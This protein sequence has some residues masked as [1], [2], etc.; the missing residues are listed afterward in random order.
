[1]FSRPGKKLALLILSTFLATFIMGWGTA[2]ASEN[3]VTDLPAIAISAGVETEALVVDFPDA[4]LAFAVRAALGLA[5]GS[6]ITDADLASLTRLTAEGANIQDLSGLEY[7]V[8]LNYLSLADN[9][10]SDL[11]SLANL[12]SLR[13]MS[14]EN[15]QISDLTPL[16]NLT[17]MQ[18]LNLSYNQ[19]T[20][21]SSLANL[22][23]LYELTLEGNQI[24]D[25]SVL[26][27]KKVLWVLELG[28][29]DISDISPLSGA[30][31]LRSVNIMNNNVSDISS[32]EN[33][34]YLEAVYAWNNQVSDITPLAGLA[35]LGSIGMANNQV[36]D[37]LAL[38]GLIKLTYLNLDNNMDSEGNQITDI[39]SLANLPWLSTLSLSYNKITDISPLADLTNLT[40]V[41]V[42]YNFIDVSPG[43]DALAVIESL[44]AGGA[45]VVYSPQRNDTNR[46]SVTYEA[47]G[48]TVGT[49]PLDSNNYSSG[50]TVT[51]K[52]N[53]GGLE[54]T[55]YIFGGWN[56]QSNGSG[57]NYVPGTT[58]NIGAENLTLY[59][60]WI[61]PSQAIQNFV[62]RFYQ[63]CL[64][65]DPDPSGL[66]D[67]VDQLES[68]T[69]TGADVA[70][71]FV[72]SS[73][74]VGLNV[75]NDEYLD[76]LYNAFFNREPDAGGY[77]FWLGQL[78]DG[79]SRL[80]VLA[81]FVNANEFGDLC[82]DYGINR[83]NINTSNEQIAAF[84]T[85]FY[86]ECLDRSP[87]QPGLNDWVDKLASGELT[88]A[89]VAYGFVYSSEFQA[90]V[91]TDEQY[92]DILYSAFFNRESD[93]GGLT[94]WLGQL[95]GGTSRLEALAGFVNSD[96]FATLCGDYGITAGTIDI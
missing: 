95:D 39:S 25:I 48:S 8:N 62:T 79:A 38:S 24:A 49:V 53:I 89:D 36:T 82:A 47:N 76:V 45:S 67:W 7:A 73:E 42:T 16:A 72:F 94:Y 15:N 43:S 11:S 17:G 34:S 85:R 68:G 3:T 74:F 26:A 6:T 78:N 29:N 23:A 22:T 52:G 90:Q 83:G 35:N 18:D 20:E 27:N 41:D 37:I 93:S 46:Y 77:A 63:E 59:A 71:G 70:Q 84:V 10:I 66:A 2:S 80:V 32:L 5:E 75:S 57:S 60:N 44:A 9:L 30:T 69:A 21:I 64:D 31:A 81:G 51:V 40:D 1:L 56:T 13:E 54:K 96:E 92:L 65:R 14:L 28:N 87:D 4:N 12:N 19:L 91:F 61:T 88:G 58:F 50:A 55:S 86:E 33:L